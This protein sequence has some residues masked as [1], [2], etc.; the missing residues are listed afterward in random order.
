MDPFEFKPAGDLGL[1][2]L[3]RFRSCQRESGL[4]TSLTRFAWWCTLRCVFRAWNQLRIIGRENLPD[5]PPFILAA[6]HASHLDALLLMSALPMAWRDSVFP[7]AAKDV[8]FESHGVAAFGAVFVN[9]LPVWRN[10]ARAHDLRELRQRLIDSPSV[11]ILFPE[12]TRTRDGKLLPF[13]PGVGKLVAGT[14]VPVVPCFI[15]GARAAMPPG[16]R[17]LNPRRI[18]V[19]IGSPQTFR[20]IPDDREG[21]GRVA[22]S[23]GH[24]VSVLSTVAPVGRTANQGGA[25]NGKSV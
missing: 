12:G 15:E 6:N 23:V 24:A 20:D 25:S 2:G 5:H 22:A 1:G 9:A 8:F 13:K 3:A 19:T 21:W 14:E 7:I 4:A 16:W 10:S 11:Y 18:R 17:F